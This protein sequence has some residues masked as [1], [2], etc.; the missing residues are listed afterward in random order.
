MGLHCGQ[1]C[2]VEIPRRHRRRRRM[3]RDDVSRPQERVGAHQPY[4]QPG[5]IL[6]RQPR[7][8]R[9]KVKSKATQARKHSTPDLSQPE[10]PKHR[11][12]KRLHRLAHTDRRPFATPHR[13]IQLRQLAQQRQ[14]CRRCMVGHLV[15]TAVGYIADPQTVR[16]RCRHV[17]IAVPH[18]L[19][20]H[21]RPRPD[22]RR[23]RRPK[24]GELHDGPFAKPGSARF[25]VSKTFSGERFAQAAAP[26][27]C[28]Q[29]H[30]AASR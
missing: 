18:A 30:R 12:G 26:P 19:T 27:L 6:G 7:I 25:S 23:R 28:Q 24:T 13:G 17:D 10:K 15:G 5:G 4:T 8:R 11:C 1:P 3:K 22:R 21:R 20:D 29:P 2:C 16:P 14:R 9:R